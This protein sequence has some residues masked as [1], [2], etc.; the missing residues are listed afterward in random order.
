MS[1]VTPS[2]ILDIVAKAFGKPRA[3]FCLVYRRSRPVEAYIRNAAVHLIAKHTTVPVHKIWL[4]IGVRRKSKK[5]VT[6]KNI[7]EMLDYAAANPSF[8]V[9]LERAETMIDDLH[10]ARLDEMFSVNSS[11]QAPSALAAEARA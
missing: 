6:K 11:E 1:N 8:L 2:E 3:S 10:D 4:E 7:S 5:E 9:R